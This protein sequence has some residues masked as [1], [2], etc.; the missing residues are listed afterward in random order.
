MA[1]SSIE[2]GEGSPS[3]H[4]HSTRDAVRVRWL[5]TAAQGG[6]RRSRERVVTSYLGLV[7]SVASRYR[8]LGLPFD[9]LV[10][11]GSLGLL[12]AIDRYDASRGTPFDGYAGFRIRRAIRDALTNQ[13]RLIRLPKEVVQRRRA[14]DDAETRL[15]AEAAGRP[16]TPGELATTTGLSPAAV[17]NARTAGLA[18]V[19]LDQPILPDGSSLANVV[20]DPAAADPE[21]KALEHERSELLQ[22]ALQDLPNRQR[23]IVN[24]RWGIGGAP[25]SNAE[26]AAELELSSRRTQTL[27]R[28]ALYALERSLRG[29]SDRRP[30]PRARAR[31]RVAGHR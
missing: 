30:Q 24:R 9:D 28:D 27:G 10:Q 14:I 8:N 2:H 23:Y 19:S 1:S 21:L 12:E 18:P 15:A 17:L 11:E 3:P 4:A 31:A 29:P 13:A 20:A 22:A 7:R 16:P 5:V 6:D 26:L 25:V